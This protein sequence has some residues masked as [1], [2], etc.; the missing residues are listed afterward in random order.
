MP[1]LCN[2]GTCNTMIFVGDE[3]DP[4]AEVK[5]ISH[6]EWHHSTQTDNIARAKEL[7]DDVEYLLE[8]VQTGDFLAG[9]V[10][11][12]MLMSQVMKVR[13]FCEDNM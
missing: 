11:A 12:D 3:T 7:L 5:R 13:R 6:N 4:E 8:D 2:V 10:K 9:Y 1:V